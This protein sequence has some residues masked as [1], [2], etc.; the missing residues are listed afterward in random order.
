MLVTNA[1]DK[2][3]SAKISV[4]GILPRRSAVAETI[5]VNELLQSKCEFAGFDFI[6]VAP[7]LYSHR[8]SINHQYFW[9]DGIH[10]VNSGYELVNSMIHKHLMKVTHI[11]QT[12]Y[13][14]GDPLYFDEYVPAIGELE[15][16]S[17]QMFSTTPVSAPVS[18]LSPLGLYVLSPTH[19]RYTQPT[20]IYR[21]ATSF[22]YVVTHI[23]SR[24]NLT[25]GKMGCPML[26]QMSHFGIIPNMSQVD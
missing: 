10:L 21:E 20:Y 26:T 8:I 1:R 5:H 24:P 4:M 9:K 12:T 16:I 23:D 2:C 14:P 13:L 22:V 3:K 18:P 11:I 19:M 7:M 6:S 25:Q 15:L 17:P